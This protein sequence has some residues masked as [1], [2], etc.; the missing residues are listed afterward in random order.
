MVLEAVLA[1]RVGTYLG[2][3]DLPHHASSCKDGGSAN[4]D[5][6]AGLSRQTF[7]VLMSRSILGPYLGEHALA[8]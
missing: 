8:A 1:E 5:D 2:K 3:R 4:I 6:F 7:I